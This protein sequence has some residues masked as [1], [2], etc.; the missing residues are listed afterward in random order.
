VGCILADGGFYFT[1]AS[2]NFTD[3]SYTFTKGKNYFTDAFYNF[4]KAKNHFT[5]A[6][7]NITTGNSNFADASF[8]KKGEHSLLSVGIC[9]L[10]AAHCFVLGARCRGDGLD[11]AF[12]V[13]RN[14]DQAGLFRVQ[15][16]V[17]TG[18]GC[19]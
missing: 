11:V 16:F 4:T 3:A 14:V 8:L 12:D 15:D 7:Y 6:S 9:K 18:A 13:D 2:C 10:Q 1:D 19:V 5:D 17:A